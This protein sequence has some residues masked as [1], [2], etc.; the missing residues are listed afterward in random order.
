M[1]LDC[2]SSIIDGAGFNVVQKG[3]TASSVQNSRIKNCAIQNY[4]SGVFIRSS[5]AM[6]L[7]NVLVS[8]NAYSGIDVALSPSISIIG[9]TTKM[10]GDNGVL[11]KTS[12][13]AR[14]K[15][16]IAKENEHGLWLENTKN[17]IVSQ[18]AF[19]ANRNDGMI[20]KSANE[21]LIT[22]SLFEDNKNL[23][24]YIFFSSSNNTITRNNLINSAVGI[25]FNS[26][27]DN[28]AYRN[29]FFGSTN[30]A[31]DTGANA[32]NDSTMG[33]YYDIFDTAAEGCTDI[34]LNSVCD[35]PFQF[36][37]N[38]GQDP[39]PCKQPQCK[40]AIKTQSKKKVA[41]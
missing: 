31:K 1:T 35:Q 4:S 41:G 26:V 39:L 10:N 40:V 5:P 37:F 2:Q 15:G 38:Q 3:I 36:Q 33:N 9:V 11:L 29:S 22:A 17:A 8:T 12:D 18:S 28:H 14:L 13:N 23:N 7:E 34:N 30:P 27:T 24:L 19:A 25:Y 16:V 32:W 6:A 20:M 21:N